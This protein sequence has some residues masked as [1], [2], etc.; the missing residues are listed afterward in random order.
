M[1]AFKYYI[2]YEI[3]KEGISLGKGSGEVLLNGKISRKKDIG[4]IEES[5]L[6]KHPEGD[7]MIIL[8]YILMDEVDMDEEDC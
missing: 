8:N 4:D 1:K 3:Y 5:F 6:S 2:V 7:C